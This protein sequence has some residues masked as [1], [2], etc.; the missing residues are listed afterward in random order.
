MRFGDSMLTHGLSPRAPYRA[1]FDLL[2]RR[3][4]PLAGDDGRLQREGETPV[5]AAKRL[6]VALDGHVL[7]IRGPP[8][9]GKTYTGAKMI[10]ALRRRGLR[11]GVMAVSHKVIDNVLE[12][13][14][15]EAREWPPYAMAMRTS[16]CERRADEPVRHDAT[17]DTRADS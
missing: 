3:P 2:L 7:A 11:V 5:E 15:K 4:P 13:A 6:V 12:E 10:C 17:Q 1:A 16:A 9:T 14:M 8:G